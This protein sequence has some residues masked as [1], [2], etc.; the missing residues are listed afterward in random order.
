MHSMESVVF[1]EKYHRTMTNVV[2]ATEY[3]QYT[4]T[5]STRVSNALLVGEILGIRSEHMSTH[6]RLTLHRPDNN[7]FDLRLYGTQSGD[8]HHNRYDRCRRHTRDCEQR[9]DNYWN[10][11]DADGSSWSHWIRNWVSI[12]QTTPSR[13]VTAT[14]TASL[15]YMS[16][17]LTLG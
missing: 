3:L 5:W 4:S 13:D 7:R 8:R 12:L 2:L 17:M 14:K 15:V 9:H 1:T 6:S 10:V 11:L 16:C